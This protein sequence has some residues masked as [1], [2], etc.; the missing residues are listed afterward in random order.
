VRHVSQSGSV[1]EGH[2]Q[3]TDGLAIV[4]GMPATAET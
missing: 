1:S 4:V 3:P 2:W